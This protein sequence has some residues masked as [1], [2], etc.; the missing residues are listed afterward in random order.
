M[1]EQKRSGHRGMQAL[2]V[3]LTAEKECFQLG[4]AILIR[5]SIAN[6][7]AE[8]VAF[9]RFMTPFEGFYG[10]FLHVI[11]SHGKRLAYK[12]ILKKRSAPES[13]DFMGIKAGES[14]SCVFELWNAYLI[15][16]SGTYQV[17][18]VGRPR[19]NALPDSNIL[20]LSIV[21]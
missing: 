18:F 4:E 3:T 16:S 1:E 9:C 7:H 17:Q 13:S 12:G 6:P 5:F 21:G 8:Q 2:T 11:D 15:P 20:H 19:L 10:D 14:R